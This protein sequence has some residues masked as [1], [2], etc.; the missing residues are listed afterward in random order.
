MKGNNSNDLGSTQGRGGGVACGDA[1]DQELRFG[2]VMQQ[3]VEH[4]IQGVK[5]ALGLEYVGGG[6]QGGSGWGRGG[7]RTG[8]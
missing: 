4:L 1:D 3:I 8:I 5:L 7:R 6:T 2:G